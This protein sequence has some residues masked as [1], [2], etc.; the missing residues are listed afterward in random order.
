MNQSVNI[1]EYSGHFPYRYT[2]TASPMRYSQTITDT[3]VR[4]HC[5]F[6]YEYFSSVDHDL[7]LLINVVFQ[8]NWTIE[9][10]KTFR[11]L[12]WRAARVRQWYKTRVLSKDIARCD[13]KRAIG[14]GFPP[15]VSDHEE[16][17]RE[18][19]CLFV[20]LIRPRLSEHVPLQ[21]IVIK[22]IS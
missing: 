1:W 2:N 18:R 6:I 3:S 17:A 12:F 22:V 11:L 8:L 14:T 9:K 21:N 7:A 13:T 4:L 16:P 20:P 19:Y 5:V 10:V 15:P